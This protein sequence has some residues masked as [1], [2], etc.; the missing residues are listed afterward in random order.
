[1]SYLNPL[2]CNKRRLDG[3]VIHGAVYSR[4]ASGQYAENIEKRKMVTNEFWLALL[5]A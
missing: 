4:M 5:A 3:A 1:M 2:F